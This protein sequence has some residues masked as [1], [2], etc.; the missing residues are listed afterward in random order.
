MAGFL[1]MRTHRRIFAGG[2]RKRGPGHHDGFTIVELVMVIVILA[3]LGALAGPRF[4]DNHAFSERG[5]ADEFAAALRYAQ[6]IAVASGCEVRVAVAASSYALS[7]QVAQAGHCAS[8]DTSFA[9]PVLMS[10]G[11]SADG[12]APTGVTASPAQI[13]V[14]N[15]LG[16]TDLASDLAFTIG[17]HTITIEADSGLVLMP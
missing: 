2:P 5:Y 7:Q 3:I 8:S 13:F 10:T 6:K 11:D 9:V 16:Q 4:F 12:V 17:N 15:A 1:Q 14:F